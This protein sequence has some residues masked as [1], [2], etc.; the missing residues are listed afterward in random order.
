MTGVPYAERPPAE[1]RP[2]HPVNEQF[3]GLLR[4]R[5]SPPTVSSGFVMRPRL[6]E[7]LTAA[8]GHPMTL[9]SAGPG[10]GKT[11]AL[12]SWSQLGVGPGPVAWLS[13]DETDNDVRGFWSD[14]LG[15]LVI[16]GALPKG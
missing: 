6:V 15:A 11:L 1:H 4:L 14:V 10:Y 13:I 5:A 12:A 16:A 9:I 3:S 7:R 8:V 2:G